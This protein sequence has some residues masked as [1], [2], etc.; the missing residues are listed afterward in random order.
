MIERALARAAS[1][2]AGAAGGNSAAYFVIRNLGAADD[3][4][5]AARSET[6]TAVE[7]H[8]SHS[9]GH[10]VRMSQATSPVQVPVKGEVALDPGGLHLMLIGL[11]RDLEE[12]SKLTLTLQFARAGEVEV[13]L[14]ATSVCPP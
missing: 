2:D 6:A 14:P 9:D 1:E 8:Q 12:G 10:V 5:L 3:W 13:K 7:I 11:R 4:L